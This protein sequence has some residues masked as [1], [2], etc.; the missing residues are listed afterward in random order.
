MAGHCPARGTIR[1]LVTTALLGAALVAALAPVAVAAPSVTI[2]EPLNNTLTNDTT[3]TFGGTAEQVAGV[4][5]LR[6]YAGAPIESDLVQKIPIVPVMGTWSSGPVPPLRDGVYTATASQTNGETGTSAPI[7][8]TIRTSAPVVTLEPPHPAPGET[9]PSFAGTASETTPVLIQIHE[10]ESEAGTIVATARA[11]GT[12][13]AWHSGP[14]SLPLAVGRYTAVAVQ[15]SSLTGNP[16]GRS[17]PMIFEI[18]PPSPIVP[19]TTISPAP[20]RGVEAE[21]A[22]KPQAHA[23]LLAP[24]PVVRVTGIAFAGGVRLRLLSVQQAPAG[25]L[26]RVRCSGHGCP[27]HEV[28]RTTV[29]G[30]HGVPAIVF[31]SFQRYL[32]AGAVVRIFVTKPGTIGKYTRLRVLRG[33]LPERVDL[34][35]DAAG[36]RPIA[37]PS[38]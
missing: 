8:F 38:A 4:V 7:S 20:A 33:G 9:T 21:V 37:C 1:R 13:G 27:P 24:F 34:C 10:G 19:L 22:V 28:R 23:S 30:L 12:G 16:A 15:P 5:T 17:A 26:V 6:I 35:L 36:I 3:P 25:A 11:E 32:G 14:A 29:A 31:H 2:T 18:L